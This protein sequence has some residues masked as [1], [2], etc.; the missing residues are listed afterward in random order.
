MTG[1]ALVTGAAKRLGREMAL[2]LAGRGLDVVVHYHGSQA[3]AAE[4]AALCRDMGV[5]AATLQADL[6]VEDEMQALVPAAAE[7]IGAP[8][9]VLVN[10]ASIFEYD[11]IRSAHAK[12]LGQAP[13]I[14]PARPLRP[15]ADLRRPVPRSRCSRAAGTS[16]PRRR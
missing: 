14:E 10:S 2:Y 4:V 1:A 13:G 5:K 6:T 12:K 15:D 3:E 16:P 9:S 11:T 7:A 8:L